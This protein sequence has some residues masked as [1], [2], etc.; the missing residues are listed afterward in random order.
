MQNIELHKTRCDTDRVIRVEVGGA[1]PEKEKTIKNKS[2]DNPEDDFDE[3]C[4][5]FQKLFKICNFNFDSSLRVLVGVLLLQYKSLL[6]YF[7]LDNF[8]T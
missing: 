5:D 3:L 8:I 2:K 7:L 6:F 4:E 1:E